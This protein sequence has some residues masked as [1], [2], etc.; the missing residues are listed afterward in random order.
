MNGPRAQSSYTTNV[1]GTELCFLL[2]LLVACKPT[3]DGPSP[4]GNRAMAAFE[5]VMSETLDPNYSD[6]AFD[7]VEALMRKV[8]DSAGDHGKSIAIAD[9]IAA[10]RSQQRKLIASL[11]AA[12][13]APPPSLPYAED[14]VPER[15]S[16]VPNAAQPSATRPPAR[17]DSKR[18]RP[19]SPVLLYTT[20]WCGVCKRAKSWFAQNN[21]P[22]REYDI[23]KSS[24]AAQALGRKARRQ[25]LKI[26]GVPVIE[27]G[28]RLHHGFS[29]DYMS[30]ELKA[31]GYL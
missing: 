18:R 14:P 27:I 8:P 5:R 2:T 17:A 7:E 30:Q 10:G 29:P 20:D 31:A 21:I 15:R 19:S 16:P 13:A 28:G 1:R 12:L 4:E 11:E 23:E 24:S 9:Q 22:F 6:P 25:G 3:S 26:T